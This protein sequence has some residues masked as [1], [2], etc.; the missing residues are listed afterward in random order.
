MNER[1]PGR[2]ARPDVLLANL[3]T[4][5]RSY[6][7]LPPLGMAYTA[8]ALER[9]GYTVRIIDCHAADIDA[10]SLADQ[11]RRMRPRIVAVGLFT[12]GLN[13]FQTSYRPYLEQTRREGA[14]Q[15]LVVGGHHVNH[16]PEIVE[17]L[18]LDLGLHG[19]GVLSMPA[20]V[21]VL[22]RDKGTLGDVPG[23]L[24]RDKSGRYRQNPVAFEPD[25]DAFPRPARH[26]LDRQ[27]YFHPLSQGRPTVAIVTQLGCPFR[28]LYCSGQDLEY[29][30][31]VRP[32]SIADVGDEVGECLEQGYGF[33]EVSDDSFTISRE[34]STALAEEFLSRG[35]QFRWSVQTRG[36]L[37]D[38]ETLRTM[39]RAGCVKVSFGFGAGNEDLRLG[40]VNKRVSNERFRQ[41]ITWAREFGM[42]TVFNAIVGFPG[43]TRH[44][45]RET[46]RRVAECDP[47]LAAFHPLEIRPGSGY[48]RLLRERGS[49][50][51]DF[52]V[53]LANSG[54][55]EV[56]DNDQG[57]QAREIKRRAVQMSLRYYLSPRRGA[58]AA[59]VLRGP[60]FHHVA[61]NGLSLFVIKRLTRG[62]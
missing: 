61:R 42:T 8:A 48:W 27:L 56:R 60:V 18:G 58:R 33:I 24:Y 54:M 38:R 20:L 26:L 7:V 59:R 36:D 41:A 51:D 29:N 34:R 4:G 16:E 62:G 19:D 37:V 35:Y 9:R 44:D 43:E 10:P 2:E 52:F 45:M 21:D 15:R 5:G 25:F 32:R 11:V 23:A 1:S 53:R 12:S 39:A 3:S 55:G 22:L 30:R 46:Y 49:V 6:M 47:D 50:P 28:C 57:I 14:Y 17:K 31:A 13:L 40:V